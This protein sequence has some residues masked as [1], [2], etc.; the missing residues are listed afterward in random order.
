MARRLPL[1]LISLSGP[2]DLEGVID[3][4]IDP[5]AGVL[6]CE[7]LAAVGSLSSDFLMARRLTRLLSDLLV[8]P[9]FLESDFERVIDRVPVPGSGVLSWE[10]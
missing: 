5:R 9:D 2:G 4:V 7:L 3:L 1:V 10:L 8:P 6:S